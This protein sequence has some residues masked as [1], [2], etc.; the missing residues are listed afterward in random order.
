LKFFPKGIITN[1]IKITKTIVMKQ[2]LYIL[3]ATNEN[4]ITIQIIDSQFIEIDKRLILLPRRINSAEFFGWLK[5]QKT[6]FGNRIPSVY[7][8]EPAFC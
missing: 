5:E 8:L 3:L 6:H 4:I 1:G 2:I 7:M